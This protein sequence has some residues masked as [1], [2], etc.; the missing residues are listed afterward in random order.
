MAK[1]DY[2][3]YWR[4]IRYWI[5]SKYDVGTA[6]IEMMLFLYSENIFSKKM[7]AQFEQCMSWDENRFRRLVKEGWIVLWRERKGRRA[8]LYKLSYKGQT[9]VRTIYRKLNGEEIGESPSLNP[10]FRN[11]AS[12]MDKQYRKMIV[13]MNEFIKQQRRLAQE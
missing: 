4:V 6:D 11:D 8:N 5:Q 3:K 10:L 9:L 13:E 7:F 2:M 1:T 12:Y